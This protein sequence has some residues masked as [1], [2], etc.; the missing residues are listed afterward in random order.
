MSE[1]QYEDSSYP[2]VLD[3]IDVPLLK[4]CPYAHQQ[5]NWR[6]DP[7]RY[8][9]KAGRATWRALDSLVDPIAPLWLD[10]CHT[11]NGVNDKVPL[12]MVNNLRSSLRL[13]RVDQITLVVYKTG[14]EFGN[15][16]RNVQGRFRYDGTEYWLRVTDPKYEQRYR[17]KPTG[18]Y[19]I[20]ESFLTVSLA[21]PF[22]DACYKLIAA[23]IERPG[24][25]S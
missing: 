5:E 6:L 21:K 2:R 12:T 13:I 19:E 23:I 10:G 15:P 11:K 1:Q 22:K 25:S 8:W 7:N 3:V 17:T 14:E 20:S 18:C 24:D 4:A 9:H 16:K